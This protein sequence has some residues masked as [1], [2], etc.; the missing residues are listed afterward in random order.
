VQNIPQTPVQPSCLS[1][2]ALDSTFSSTKQF[3][4]HL[5]HSDVMKALWY[6]HQAL[7]RQPLITPFSLGQKK[8]S[9]PLSWEFTHVCGENATGTAS[10][11]FG[12]EGFISLA[13]WFTV[14]RF[15]K[16]SADEGVCQHYINVMTGIGWCS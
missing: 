10:W 12:L 13:R 6:A 4:A 9:G 5:L 15:R 2:Q 1:E 14:D 3:P 11:K 16:T 8:R 7:V